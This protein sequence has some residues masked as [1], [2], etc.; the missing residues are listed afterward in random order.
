MKRF[1]SIE[2]KFTHLFRVVVIL[3]NFLQKKHMDLTYQVVGDPN[4]DLAT[5]GWQGDF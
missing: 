1:D 2:S 3:I 5:H 4:L